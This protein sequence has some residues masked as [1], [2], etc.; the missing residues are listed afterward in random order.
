[1][2]REASLIES[3]IG[4]LVDSL[5]AWEKFERYYMGSLLPSIGRMATTPSRTVASTVNFSEGEAEKRSREAR[6]LSAVTQLR[7]QLT[8][9]EWRSL[10][11]LVRE[12]RTGSGPKVAVQAR[13]E[14]EALQILSRDFLKARYLW[15]GHADEALLSESE[16]SKLKTRFVRDWADRELKLPLDPEQAA[17]VAAVGGDIKVTARAGAGKTRTLVT[18]AIFLQK[19]CGVAPGE[20]LLL[21]FNRAAAE[22][23]RERL[24]EHLGSDVPHVMTFHALAHAL[25]HP[26]EELLFDEPA[27]GSKALSREVQRVID[28]HLR[29]EAFRPLIRDLMLM[30]FRDDWEQIVDGGFHLPIDELVEYR[31]SLPRETLK[32]EYVKSYGEKL[33]ANTLFEN[34][35]DYK[36]ESNFRWSGVNYKPDFLVPLEDGGSL[37]IEYF[38]LSGDAD[39]DEMS[40]EKREFWSRQPK[41]IFYEFAPVDIARAGKEAFKDLLLAEL[42]A[43]GVATHQL[44][45]EEIWERIQLRAI[46]HFTEAATS[47]VSRCRK[48]NL[49]AEALDRQL[50]AHLPISDAERLFLE[51]V[52]SVYRGYLQQLAEGQQEDFDGLIWRAAN[53]LDSGDGRFTRDRGRERGDVRNLRFVLVDEFQD[54]SEMFYALARGIHSLNP[55]AQFF[56]VGDDWQAINGFAGSDLKFFTDFQRY[57]RDT[58]TLDVRT[59]YRSHGGVVATGNALMAGRGVAAVADKKDPGWVRI[60]RLADFK[61]SPAEQERHNGDEA[62]PAL[63]RLVKHFFDS[64]RD[65]VML[66]RT[67]RV[68][69]YVRYE[70]DAASMA[71]ALERFAEHIRS[72]FPEED[73]GRLK[74]STSHKYK[75]L[76]S[77]AVIILDADSYPLVHPNWIFLRALGDS[78]ARIEDEERRLFYVALTRSEHSLVI[79][80]ESSRR[81]SPFLKDT[82]ERMSTTAVAWSELPPP[83]SLDAPRLEIRVRAPYD[84]ELREQLKSRRFRW[85]PT[86]RYWW[87]LLPADAFDFEKLSSE[88]WAKGPVAIEIMT[89][90]GQVWPH[91]PTTTGSSTH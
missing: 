39:Y 72:F 20:L 55:T 37:V 32:G 80:S 14:Q 23:M 40:H 85:N 34:D 66:A 26:E 30:H 64:G 11:G 46:D 62:T 65:V 33:I 18:R 69:W 84:Q 1:M 63:L 21:A 76:E 9:D 68:P 4:Q 24:K 36:Y 42:H 52:S 10:P 86:D 17:A 35:V 82:R 74:I 27:A 78:V 48:A 77:P 15:R 91:K 43:A 41:C 16:F 50:A 28:D 31:K 3:L 53:R 38:G 12:Y 51:V 22:V 90:D 2:R 56:C 73:R 89:E 83:P 29:S 59:N 71:G 7:E 47:F 49:M 13:A 70:T 75:G 44:T 88:P 54:F 61:P 6:F 60:A 67:N 19:H 57:F 5:P 45:E 87:R 8:P 25:V 81:E 58:T 79:L